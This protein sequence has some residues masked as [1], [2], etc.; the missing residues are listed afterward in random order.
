[1]LK[2]DNSLLF[3]QY[4]VYIMI[5]RFLTSNIS[6]AVALNY[7]LFNSCLQKYTI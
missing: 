5:Y 7:K 4:M 2:N 3:L 6:K 1:M